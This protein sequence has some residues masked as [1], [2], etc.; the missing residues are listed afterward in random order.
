M[1]IVLSSSACYAQP[2][3]KISIEGFS[4][5]NSKVS[6]RMNL[7]INLKITNVGDQIGYCEDLYGIWLYSSDYQYNDKIKYINSGTYL[8]EDIKPGDYINS[9]ITFEVPKNADNL[10]L[11]FHE[12]FGGARKYITKSYNK[13]IAENTLEKTESEKLKA[14]DYFSRKEYD[15]AIKSYIL[16]SNYDKSRKEEFDKKIC[17]IYLTKANEVYEKY[18]NTNA[19]YHLENYLEN[20][21]QA[22]VYDKNNNEI[23][24]KI[25]QY[26]ELKGDEKK[27]NNLIVDAISDYK[28]SLDYYN[29]YSVKEKLNNLENN[30]SKKK[31]EIKGRITAREEYEQI[32]LPDVGVSLRGGIGNQLNSN[33]QNSN[34]AFWNLQVDL[35]IKLYTIEPPGPRFSFVLNIDLGYQGSI[36]GI[37]E[38]KR[39]LK[40]DSII[41]SNN[42]PL[43]GQLYFNSGLGISFLNKTVSPILTFEYG[44]YYQHYG[45]EMD[46]KYSSNIYNTYDDDISKGSIGHGF[47]VDLSILF[48]KNPS[49]VIGY[50]YRNYSFKSDIKFLNNRYTEHSFNIGI[51]NF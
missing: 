3:F 23:K 31:S 37:K 32:K 6:E 41:S 17:V 38:I 7:Q 48:W 34:L 16:C 51:I 19:D 2:E 20:L 42:G 43:I 45:F 10:E 35:P 33:N 28:I 25:A 27:N 46:T 5:N 39:Y 44:I 9:F 50:N 24:Y 47:K 13:Y 4:W 12:N 21:K 11:K 8:L 18:K 14:E 36:G 22:L 49:L 26:Y 1:L 40:N 29:S 30:E 15:M